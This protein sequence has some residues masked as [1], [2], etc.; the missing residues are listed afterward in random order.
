MFSDLGK[1]WGT[2]QSFPQD[3]RFGLQGVN[4]KLRRWKE[5]VCIRQTKV[6][7]K[8]LRHGRAWYFGGTAPISVWWEYN[9]PRVR[10][11][12]R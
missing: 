7:A 3:V 12:D 1:G 4:K 8:A 6:H 9:I 11:R 2:W 5:A 10:Y